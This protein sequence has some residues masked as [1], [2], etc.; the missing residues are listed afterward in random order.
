MPKYDAFISFRGTDVRNFFL[1]HL[2]AYMNNEKHILTYKDDVNLKRGD[3]IA[4][5]L[6]EAIERSSL[7]VVIFSPNYATSRWCLDE[8]VRILECTKK[9][10]R[11]MIPVFYGGVA[12]SHVRN[13]EASYKDAFVEHKA[14]FPNDEAKLENWKAALKEAADT[15]GFDSQVTTPESHLVKEVTKRVLEAIRPNSSPITEGL[16]GIESEIEAVDKLLETDPQRN[17]VIGFWGMPGIGKT[18]LASSIF[19][20]IDLDVFEGGHYI[21]DFAIQLKTKTVKD[22]Q[23]ELFKVLLRDDNPQD[24]AFGHKLSRLRRLRAFVVIDDVTSASMQALEELL[25]WKFC[26]LF[27]PGSRMILTSTNQQV[28]INACQEVHQVPGLDEEK[29]LQLFSFYAFKKDQPPDEY[30]ERCEK[31][32]AYC[33]GNPLALRV[34]G[35]AFYKKKLDLWD[36]TLEKLR[37]LHKK[38]IQDLLMISYNE[39]S[40]DEQSAFLD[41]ACFFNHESYDFVTRVLD[42]DL[43]T[44]LADKSLVGIDYSKGKIEMHVL[45]EDL[46]QDIVEAETDPQKRTRWWEVKDTLDLLAKNKGTEAT[47]GIWLNL[48]ENEEKIETECSDTFAKMWNL[49]VLSIELAPESKVVFPNGEGLINTLPRKLTYLRW[50]LF[51]ATSLPSKFCPDKLRVLRLK[52]NTIRQLWDDGAK[53]DLGNLRELNLTA[54]KYL[55]KLPDLSTAKK[56]ELI[57]LTCCETLIELHTS[58]IYLPSLKTL[59]L[60]SCKALDL[61]KLDEEDTQGTVAFPRLEQVNL[62]ATPIEKVPRLLLRAPNLT[63]IDCSSCPNLSKF[64]S[65]DALVSSSSMSIEHL[66]FRNNKLLVDFPLKIHMLNSLQTL[67]FYGCENLGSFPEIA[68]TMEKLLVLDLSYCSKVSRIPNTIRNLA[69][70]ERLCL[71]GTGIKELPSSVLSLKRLTVLKFDECKKL[72]KIPRSFRELSHLETMAFTGCDALSNEELLLPDRVHVL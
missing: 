72:V 45:L 17:R 6:I 49:R 58:V 62:D 43:V 28:L 16:V 39:L 69:N 38:D 65:I 46:G 36:L 2:F 15:S 57:D 19:Q 24:I 61:S 31:V 11:K 48:D 50:D 34:L 66:I 4:P 13:Q 25:D 7:Y 52:H 60:D 56:L 29:S 68:T 8:L 55:T 44:N 47:E 32:V 59:I 26:N 35:V 12:P 54:S 22:L 30:K 51:A 33:G 63:K 27:G 53:T 20:K 70:L 10:G 40:R 42:E 64:P 67:D 14:K 21:Q 1:S 41:I 18:T 5:S 71:S 37:T 3:I 23:N 9:Y